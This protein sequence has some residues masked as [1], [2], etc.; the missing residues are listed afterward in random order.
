MKRLLAL[1]FVMV[2]VLTPETT[3]AGQAG[4]VSQAAIEVQQLAD[5]LFLLKHGSHSTPVLITDLGV[6]IVDPG[7]AGFGAPV[8]AAVRRL[9][10]RPIATLINSDAHPDHTGANDQFGTTVDIVAH[11]HTR[12]SLEQAG[13]FGSDGANFLPKLMVRTRMSLGAGQSRIDLLH[14]GRAH[15]N[16][17]LWVVFPAQRV[18][19]AG[20][21]F[22]GRE[23]PIIDG[24]QGGSGLDYPDTLERAAD[25]LGNIDA[26]VSGE[27]GLMRRADF[28][29]FRALVREFH[30]VVIDGFNRGM[31]AD[32]VIASW[33]A[34]AP[35]TATARADRV[36]SNVEYMFGELA[37][38]EPE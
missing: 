14:F 2:Q 23:L 17:D 4:P 22:P 6:V 30:D 5:D 37:S 35:P 18:A 34:N 19:Y 36:R 27:Q 7:G 3:R 21:V 31:S 16:G 15:T 10:D 32:E 20:D 26:I 1:A 38:G 25:A 33:Q 13:A 24:S 11:E 12:K 29:G 9:T 8:I 28:D